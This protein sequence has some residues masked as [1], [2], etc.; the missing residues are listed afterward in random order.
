MEIINILSRVKDED[1]INGEIIY[2]GMADKNWKLL[3]SLGRYKDL[4]DGQEYNLVKNLL[5]LRPEAF[6]NLNSN[7]EI[8]SKNV[9]VCV[10]SIQ[11]HKVGNKN[12]F[13]TV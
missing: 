11:V 1:F 3:P 10:V 8:L 4:S 5:S 12:M 13:E 7:F 9:C 6:I 2:R